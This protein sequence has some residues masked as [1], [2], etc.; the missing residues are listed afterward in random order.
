MKAAD[1]LGEL[2]SKIDAFTARVAARYP[3]ALACG[4]GCSDCCRRELTVTSVE[5]ARITRE[6][7]TL[8]HPSRERLA[9]RARGGGPCVALGEDG[10]CSIYAARPVVCR[11]HGLPI[12]FEEPRVGGERRLPIIDVCPKNF[13]EHDLAAVDPAS[14]LDQRTLSV[15]LG[16]LDAL[17]AEGEG[18]PAG[19][20]RPLR[21]V[22]LAAVG[23]APE[24]D[25]ASG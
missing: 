22:V 10:R 20:R 8:D 17:H 5:A 4:P 1:R 16:A 21:E 12:R 7:L 18:K 15:L 13:T 14:V 2:W 19:L 6:V 23:H 9:R 11:S 24:G 25:A 3:G